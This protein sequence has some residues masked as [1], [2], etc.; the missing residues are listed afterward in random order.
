MQDLAQWLEELGMSEYSQRFAEDDA[1]RAV[2][3]ALELITRPLASEAK[4]RPLGPSAL[5]GNVRRQSTAGFFLRVLLR[6]REIDLGERVAVGAPD[7]VAGVRLLDRPG[8]GGSG[9][10]SRR[11]A[12]ISAMQ[13]I[14][15]SAASPPAS[16]RASRTLHVR[17][18]RALRVG[19]TAGLEYRGQKIR[20][21][22]VTLDRF[23]GCFISSHKHTR[24]PR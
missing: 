20:V 1:E 10:L 24:I 9:G 3:A 22:I 16:D 13:R 23:K 4:R 18:S 17:R 12:F 11:P 19:A 14:E 15:R 8:R 7:D 2:R 5:H 6:K 21:L